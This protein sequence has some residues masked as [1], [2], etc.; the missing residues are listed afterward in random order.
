MCVCVCWV[1]CGSGAALANVEAGMD[2]D[3]WSSIAGCACVHAHLYAR[4]SLQSGGAMYVD[5]TSSVTVSGGSTIANSSAAQVVRCS[6]A[7][8]VSCVRVCVC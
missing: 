8:R 4:T 1:M 7:V 2:E 5:G 6:V 3:V